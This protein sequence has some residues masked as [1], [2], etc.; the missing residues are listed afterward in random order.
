MSET[1][2]RK[3]GSMRGI[4]LSTNEISKRPRYTATELGELHMCTG[5]PTRWLDTYKD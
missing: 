5:R 3:E 4:F 1:S 2:K